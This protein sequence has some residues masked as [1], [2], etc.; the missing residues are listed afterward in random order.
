VLQLLRHRR[1][2]SLV[3]VH[4]LS[5]VMQ[6]GGIALVA[7]ADAEI[8]GKRHVDLETGGDAVEKRRLEIESAHVYAE[9]QCTLHSRKKQR[10][11]RHG[12]F[13]QRPYAALE[14]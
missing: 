1:D 11:I 10:P 3:R 7:V 9:F 12:G 6:A 14:F 4:V 5:K 2:N 8:N 13:A